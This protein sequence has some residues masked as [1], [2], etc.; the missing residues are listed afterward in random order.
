MIVGEGDLATPPEHAR[1]LRE[2]VDGARLE[3]IEGAAHISNLEAPAVFGSLLQ[4]FLS[5]PAARDQG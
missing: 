3:V 5:D 1:W 4:G 2:H